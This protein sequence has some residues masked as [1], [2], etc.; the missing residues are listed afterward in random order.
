[1]ARRVASSS[2]V[3]KLISWPS[4]NSWESSDGSAFPPYVSLIGLARAT[5]PG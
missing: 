5:A 2:F 4:I 1:M 3:K